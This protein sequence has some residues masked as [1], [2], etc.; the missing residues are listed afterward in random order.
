MRRVS[1]TVDRLMAQ[2]F[3]GREA[4]ER[5]LG[6]RRRHSLAVRALLITAAIAL[7]VAV[8]AGSAAAGTG[9]AGLGAGA[10]HH[11][12]RAR[13]HSSHR[14]NAHRARHRAASHARRTGRRA[15]DPLHSR[16]MWIWELPDTDG[17]DLSSIIGGAHYYRIT[18]LIIKSSD[19]VNLWSQFSPQL[20]AELHAAHLRV[21]AWQYVYGNRPGVEA[22]LGADAVHDGADCLVIDAESEYEGRYV[23]AQAYIHD[24]R[25]QIG[26]RYPVALAGF[27]YVDYH[28]G[29]PYSIFLGPGGAQYDVPQMYWRDIGT[30]VSAVFAHTYAFNLP[31]G[32]PID[33]LGQVYAN[34]PMR[35][36]V[37]F[38][39]LARSYGAG[40]VSW[41]DW[42]EA[43]PRGWTALSERTERLPEA[44]RP[45]T[46]GTVGRRARG[47]LVVWIQEHLV[48]AGER[49]A[50][51]GTFGART[52]AAVEAFQIAHG[53]VADGLV[54][55]E[56]WAALLRYKPADVRWVRR[57]KHTI[58]TGADAISTRAAAAASDG[59]APL[60]LPVPASGSRPAR[61]DEI[62]G[63]LGSGR[64]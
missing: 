25:K 37:R 19:G 29:F 14:R 57:G 48:S 11:R 47:D 36:I 33:P 26:A 54:G 32:R 5:S 35:Q 58:A 63:Q 50:I 7:L 31:Y 40:G 62:P 45:L 17:G 2:D 44:Q 23:A 64:R 51:D 10:H 28:P 1:A 27:P 16:A 59:G 13:R 15:D 53:L 41:W 49:G 34:P 21:C 12:S 61:R 8:T 4:S 43:R 30:S 24:L 38:R 20:V 9:G 3:A 60:T 55:P 22:N 52:Q 6:G 39:E 42:Q 46:M 56:T 18:T